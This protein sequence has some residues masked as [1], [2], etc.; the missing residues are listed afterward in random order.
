LARRPLAGRSS[1]RWPVTDGPSVDR[2]AGGRRA[3]DAES[4]ARRP[5]EL[6]IDIDAERAVTPRSSTMR[7]YGTAY[8]RASRATTRKIRG[9]MCR[10]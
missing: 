3:I 4:R 9:S 7:T 5:R 10:C 8:S 2:P 6:R 1:G